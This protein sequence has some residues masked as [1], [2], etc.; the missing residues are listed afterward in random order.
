M[1]TGGKVSFAG[2]REFGVSRALEKENSNATG[3]TGAHAQDPQVDVSTG[4][5]CLGRPA[6]SVPPIVH[7]V[8]NYVNRNV[9]RRLG[10]GSSER[11]SGS[12]SSGNMYI[13]VDIYRCRYIDVDIYI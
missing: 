11:T 6:P 13:Y 2:G 3:S 1:S 10:S 5:G 9:P 7:N 8:K 4:P 12:S